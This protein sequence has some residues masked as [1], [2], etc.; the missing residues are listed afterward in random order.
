MDSIPQGFVK[1][2]RKIIWE[3]DDPLQKCK[4]P[5]FSITK[6]VIPDKTVSSKHSFE[7]FIDGNL[8]KATS[9]DTQ[10]ID[11]CVKGFNFM[12]ITHWIGEDEISSKIETEIWYYC[13]GSGEYGECVESFL[14]SLACFMTNEEPAKQLV[15]SVSF[16]T[17]V[18]LHLRAR[19]NP[20]LLH[21]KNPSVTHNYGQKNAYFCLFLSLQLHT[22]NIVFRGAGTPAYNS[23]H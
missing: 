17:Y 7:L 19:K 6:L 12:D 21:S 2:K 15:I 22:V 9:C 20:P 3:N 4:Y 10:Q 16:I 11:E 13:E 8:S 5:R 14:V 1:V 18:F 23:R